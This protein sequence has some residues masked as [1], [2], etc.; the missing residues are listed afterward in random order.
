MTDCINSVNNFNTFDEIQLITLAGAKSWAVLLYFL[1]KSLVSPR[2]LD[3]W[4]ELIVNIKKCF[5][6]CFYC[7]HCGMRKGINP[8]QNQHGGLAPP[9]WGAISSQQAAQYWTHN[10]WTRE[11][12]ANNVLNPAASRVIDYPFHVN[13]MSGSPDAHM[14]TLCKCDVVFC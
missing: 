1:Q 5:C 7:R 10:T 4:W 12:T 13:T 14:A 9:H 6:L 2:V 8:I 3:F 11:F